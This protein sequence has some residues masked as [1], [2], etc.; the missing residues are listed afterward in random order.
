MLTYL[1]DE[2]KKITFSIAVFLVI[3]TFII[4][5][6]DEY[7]ALA[8]IVVLAVILSLIAGYLV[9]FLINYGRSISGFSF[10]AAAVVA[11]VIF[12][13][14][15]ALLIYLSYGPYLGVDYIK[16]G[17]LKTDGFYLWCFFVAG[18]PVTGIVMKIVKIYTKLLKDSK[19]VECRLSISHRMDMPIYIDQLV[20]E[21]SVNKMKSD[22]DIPNRMIEDEKW[23]VEIKKYYNK[24]IIFIDVSGYFIPKSSDRINMS[25]YAFV[26]DKYYCDV[27]PFNY[28]KFIKDDQ[29]DS[30]KKHFLQKIFPHLR[31]QLSHN[32]HLHYKINGDVD[33]YVEK[34][35]SRLQVGSYV[36][37]EIKDIDEGK[38]RYFIDKYTDDVESAETRERLVSNIGNRGIVEE[39][40]SLRT[41]TKNVQPWNL[42]ISGIGF[43][44]YIKLEDSVLNKYTTTYE[45]LA[46]DEKRPLPEKLRLVENTDGNESYID[47]TISSKDLYEEFLKLNQSESIAISLVFGKNR[48]NC[49]FIIKQG[50]NNIDFDKYYLDVQKT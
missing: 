2:Y 44:K 26:E 42:N 19:A 49:S 29:N 20:F 4:F 48:D 16:T 47:M 31:R 35:R 43:D 41:F 18:I 21:N 39:I 13:I 7:H 50:T 34:G 9:W 40:S 36:K 33:L 24:S 8:V 3:Q 32:I 22:F 46:R 1:S 15:T 37:T 10:V 5:Y 28:A 12:S 11:V 14:T 6:L 45:A 38:K 17:Y 27:F 25:W 23:G 30:R